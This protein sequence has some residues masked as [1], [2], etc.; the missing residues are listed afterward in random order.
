MLLS[1]QPL[2][3][4]VPQ[5]MGPRDSYSLVTSQTE[6]SQDGRPKKVYSTEGMMAVNLAY[7]D[8]ENI[9]RLIS[10]PLVLLFPLN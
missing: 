3:S 8:V 1:H 6:E 4:Y 5:Y 7:A 2:H 9:D 10:T